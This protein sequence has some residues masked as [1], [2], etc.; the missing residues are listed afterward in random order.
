MP[1]G[2]R[3]ESTETA[4]LSPTTQVSFEKY[5]RL[6]DAFIELLTMFESGGGL[7]KRPVLELRDK[8]LIESE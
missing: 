4:V 8:L 2:V 5:D 3:K 6:Y 1:R 7:H